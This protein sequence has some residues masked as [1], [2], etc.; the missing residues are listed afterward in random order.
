MIIT[1]HPNKL[2]SMIDEIYEEPPGRIDF[3]CLNWSIYELRE[4]LSKALDNEMALYL[5]Y[6]LYKSSSNPSVTSIS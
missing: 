4:V 2:F 6:E 1:D 3:K 5:I